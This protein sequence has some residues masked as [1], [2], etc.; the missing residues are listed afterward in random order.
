MRLRDIASRAA[1]AAIVSLIENFNLNHRCGQGGHAGIR[2]SFRPAGYQ[3]WIWE[4][5]AC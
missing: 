3:D 2:K 1:G 5:Q 4:N